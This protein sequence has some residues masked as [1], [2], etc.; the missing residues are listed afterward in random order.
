MQNQEPGK[1]NDAEEKP[2]DGPLGPI[3]VLS[4]GGNEV[5]DDRESDREK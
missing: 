4:F 1:R 3:S 5:T 2:E